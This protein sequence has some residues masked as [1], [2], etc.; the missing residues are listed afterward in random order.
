MRAVSAMSSE[1]RGEPDISRHGDADKLIEEEEA[2]TG[3]VS[4]SG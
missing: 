3:N 1:S 4:I 2:M